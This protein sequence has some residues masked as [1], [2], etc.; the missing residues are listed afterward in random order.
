[1]TS[2]EIIAQTLESNPLK[3]NPAYAK[4][5]RYAEQLG[6]HKAKAI[7]KALEEAGFAIVPVEPTENQLNAARDWSIKKYGRGVGNDGAEGCYKA[8]LEAA[9]AK[10]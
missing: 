7:I 5:A 3:D 9:K 1:M 6:K 8:M 10:P 2:S 4:E